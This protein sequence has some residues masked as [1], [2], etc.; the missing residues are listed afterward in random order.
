MPPGDAALLSAPVTAAALDRAA[1]TMP[2]ASGRLWRVE[3]DPPSYLV[4]TFHVPVG[5]I[6]TPGPLL[7]HLVGEARGLL[8]ELET[9]TLDEEF[10]RWSAD[11]ANVVRQDGARLTEAMSEDERAHAAAVLSRYGMPLV[12]AETLRPMMLIG[13]LSVPPC[14]IDAV[15]R[16]GL[17]ARLQGIARANG[18]PVTA[19]ETVG[20]QVTALDADP[21]ASMQIL[22]MMLAQSGD[23]LTTWFTNLALYRTRH[24]GAMWTYGLALA[25]DVLGEEE[26]EALSAVFWNRI[27]AAR[28]RRM[29]ERAAPALAAGGVVIAVGA[30]H[31]PGEDGLVALLRAA[32]FAVVPMKEPPPR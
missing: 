14:A 23:D 26:A 5:G 12:V 28:N 30:L 15:S 17:D 32:G 16:P 18:V 20:E 27:V 6:D 8:V 7:T 11:P 22:R 3:T 1:E 10:A 13:L 21:E 9:D 29:V 24:I 31:L 25:A 4:G 2:N 19:L